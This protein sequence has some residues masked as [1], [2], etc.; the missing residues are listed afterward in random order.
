MI[1]LLACL[2]LAVSQ[3]AAA[4]AYPAKPV[5]LVVGLAP[6]GATDIMA[7][8]LAPALGDGLGQPVIVDNRPG[9]AGSIGAVAVAKA[10]PGGHTLVRPP[11]SFTAHPVPPQN[12]ASAPPPPSP[13]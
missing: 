9:A 5:R 10:P 3:Y 7:R 11:S 13:A 2:L 12:G 8:T 1:R 4:Q 6:G